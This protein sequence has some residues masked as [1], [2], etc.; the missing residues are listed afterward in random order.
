MKKHP[1]WEYL[2]QNNMTDLNESDFIMAYSDPEKAKKVWSYIKDN[3]M[4]SLD[5]RSFYNSYFSSDTEY[6]QGLKKKEPSSQDL[7]QRQERSGASSQPVSQ[8]VANDPYSLTEAS[9]LRIELKRQF[10]EFYENSKGSVRGFDSGIQNESFQKATANKDAIINLSNQLEALNPDQYREMAKGF[11]ESAANIYAEANNSKGST[12][13]TED[14]FERSVKNNVTW[15]DNN[16]TWLNNFINQNSGKNLSTDV[17]LN[18]TSKGEKRTDN[19]AQQYLQ[20]EAE[21]NAR[22]KEE[23]RQKPDAILISGG[24]I[25]NFQ[26]AE[27]QTNAAIA[28]GEDIRPKRNQY[29]TNDTYSKKVAEYEKRAKDRQSVYFKD[30]DV[31]EKER[32]ALTEQQ[33][34]DNTYKFI[35]E[36][37]I[38]SGFATPK[39]VVD[40]NGVTI[41][42]NIDIDWNKLPNDERFQQMF[43]DI[44]LEDKRMYENRAM[45]PKMYAQRGNN[46]YIEF[47]N[48]VK[49]SLLKG[50]Q[51]YYTQNSTSNKDSD[52]VIQ[53]VI[54]QNFNEDNYRP[55]LKKQDGTGTIILDIDKIN[56]S[57][58]K[59]A[60]H[61]NLPLDGT[62]RRNMYHKAESK[63]RSL[64]LKDDADAFLEANNPEL[65]EKLRVEKE[66]NPEAFQTTEEYLNLISSF[67]S[68][69][70]AMANMYNSLA[71]DEMDKLSNDF[72]AR[73][74]NVNNKYN[75][76]LS[77]IQTTLQ[78]LESA[79][80][81]NRISELEYGSQRIQL[82]K[83]YTDLYNQYTAEFPTQEEFL[84]AQNIALNAFTVKSQKE[85]DMMFDGLNQQLDQLFKK[86]STL[87]PALKAELEAAM[88]KAYGDAAD[89][90]G[91]EMERRFN[92]NESTNMAHSQ[93]RSYLSGSFGGFLKRIGEVT[94]SEGM[95]QYGQYLTE[96]FTRPNAKLDEFS[97]LLDFDNFVALLGEASGTTI[98][99]LAVTAGITIASRGIGAPAAFTFAVN[100][101]ASTAM[102]VAQASGSAQYDMYEKTGSVSKALNAASEATK[103]EMELWWLHI[104]DAL[105]FMK[106]FGGLIKTPRAV[107]LIL[108]P[109]IELAKETVEET[110][111]S[112]YELNISEGR[113]R[114]DNRVVWE[115]EPGQEGNVVSIKENL[116][117]SAPMSLI[118]GASDIFSK[119]DLTK[120]QQ[121]RIKYISDQTKKIVGNVVDDQQRQY[122]QGMVDKG[123]F[124]QAQQALAGMYMTGQIDIEEFSKVESYIAQSQKIKQTADEAK[125]KGVDRD[126]YSFFTARADE[127]RRMAEKNAND[128]VMSK[129]FEMQSK[130]YTQAAADFL[131]TR[132]VPTMYTV[133]HVDGTRTMMTDSDFRNAMNDDSFM[134]MVAADKIAVTA[135]GDGSKQ[136]MDMF[137]EKGKVYEQKV[138]EIREIPV[139]ED[140]RAQY[141]SS[142]AAKMAVSQ[143]ITRDEAVKIAT[144]EWLQTEDGIRY[145]NLNSK[146][147]TENKQ[148]ISSEEQQGKEPVQAE[149][150]Q[151]AGTTEVAPGG[152]VQGA[153]EEVV[154][155]EIPEVL[156]QE[157][158]TAEVTPE[159]IQES[160]KN[161]SIGGFT[162][163][164]TT[165]GLKTFSGDP[166]LVEDPRSTSNVSSPDF[167][168]RVVESEKDGK[169]VFTYIG[170]EVDSDSFGRPGF[171]SVSLQYPADT[172]LTADDVKPILQAKAA[173]AAGQIKSSPSAKKVDGSSFPALE[174]SP[175]VSA[176]AEPKA[177]TKTEVTPEIKLAPTTEV[178]PKKETK[179]SAAQ[180]EMQ[181]PEPLERND[182]NINEL[183]S[184]KNKYNSLPKT[185]KSIGAKLLDQIKQDARDMDMEVLTTRGLNIKIVDKKTKKPISK[186][187][188]SRVANKETAQK[189]R[190]AM[191][192]AQTGQLGIRA[193]ILRY[194]IGGGKAK[195]SQSELGA[196]SIEMKEAKKKG[197]IS[198]DSKT[199]SIDNI[200][201]YDIIS[202]IYGDA[203][204]AD[205]DVVD[206]VIAE[207]QD[208]LATYE[209][210]S[211]MEYDLMDM[212]DRVLADQEE[213]SRYSSM[214]EAN[215]AIDELELSED[216]LELYYESQNPLK[217]N[218]YEEY[219]RQAFPEYFNEEAEG[220]P[221]VGD[222]EGRKQEEK[223]KVDKRNK[224]RAELSG[225]F[226]EA[227]KNAETIRQGLADAGISVNVVS[228]EEMEDISKKKGQF[229]E[230]ADGIFFGDDGQIYLREDRASDPLFGK[231]LA[232]H[233]GIHPII[234]IIRNTNPKLYKAIVDGLNKLA[235]TNPGI[236]GAKDWANQYD[237][238]TKEDEFVVESLARLS[239]GEIDPLSIP[240]NLLDKIIDL[241]NKISKALFGKSPLTYRSS[242]KEVQKLSKQITD[243]FNGYGRLADVVGKENV[244][245]Y[246]YK[247]TAQPSTSRG[248]PSNVEIVNGF[249][250]PIEKSVSEFGKDKQKAK[251]WLNVVGKKDEAIYTGV[252]G[253]LEAKDPQEQVSKQDILDFMKDNRIEIKEKTISA[254]ETFSDESKWNKQKFGD[255]VWTMNSEDGTLLRIDAS[256]GDGTVRVFADDV[257]IGA[258]EY[259]GNAFEVGSSLLDQ[260]M[261]SEP[262]TKYSQY[263]LEG[264]KSGYKEVLVTL[265]SKVAPKENPNVVITKDFTARNGD[266]H[267][268]VLDKSTGEEY[269]HIGREGST[270]QSVRQE[271]LIKF[272]LQAAQRVGID[273]K[274][275]HFEEPNILVHLRMNTRTDA[276]GNK[277]LFL[278]EVQS[279]WGQ[280][281]KKRGFQAIGKF[282]KSKVSTKIKSP[283]RVD[284]YYDGKFI[285]DL[286]TG[287][288]TDEEVKKDVLN[289]AKDYFESTKMRSTPSAPFVTDTNAW[290]KL[291]LKFALQEAVKQGVNKIAWTTG[292]QQFDRW[293]SEK[294]DWIKTDD[295][296]NISIQEQFRGTAFEGM[297]VDEKALSKNGTAIKSKEDLKDSIDEVLSR[298][299][300][301]QERQKLADRVWDR[302]QNEDSGTS[303]PRKEGMESFYGSVE[304]NK[305]GIVGGVANALV[306]ELTGEPAKIKGANIN[307][308][309]QPSI[310]VTPDLIEQVNQGIPQFA[311][312]RAGGVSQDTILDAMDEIDNA[313]ESGV[314]AEQAIQENILNQPWYGQLSDDQ[315]AKVD[316]VINT[317]Y[318]VNP[319][320]IVTAS[321]SAQK[322]EDLY[323]SQEK[324]YKNKIQ[325]LLADD[326]ELKYIYNNIP[327]IL[328]ALEQEGVIKKNKNCP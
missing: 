167:T 54:D 282:D 208:V 209:D 287:Y 267:F 203:D 56:E 155:E 324:G 313:I 210:K 214:S 158:V 260:D 17:K 228:K 2:K 14:A 178:A 189:R 84:R 300:T 290:T 138:G 69:T 222:V 169:K 68:N 150:V 41:V 95:V 76:Q 116:I 50:L 119:G 201:R 105:P 232:F 315:K 142:R 311:V 99:T 137:K 153:Q 98:P 80:A 310:D 90:R 326:P 193:A 120:E 143:G 249:Y 40:D 63:M 254:F 269:K 250:S 318:G 46:A 26:E 229:K 314:S 64:M 16:S 35:N 139:L 129:V 255:G 61:Y 77:Q 43:P 23:M 285:D 20:E 270:P 152:V 72:K 9:K 261:G 174:T 5:E 252:R 288:S 238:Q 134:T 37:A 123:Q 127:S 317:E 32:D 328:N 283:N 205:P 97:D 202:S 78:E 284:V 65:M 194:F 308:Q 88:N 204:N 94:G 162:I 118:G 184:K 258:D 161:E 131:T 44:S 107:N 230:V 112:N 286:F 19:K 115:A 110:L 47:E 128:P 48:K 253:W 45:N 114:W 280:E 295:G 271:V 132:I 70:L 279:D 154:Q 28:A 221:S 60:D 51:D 233:E 234:N 30:W 289:K 38:S 117:F 216:E 66:K 293:G 305:E 316:S 52:V 246:E 92:A 266:V 141:V 29:D 231:G 10:E 277:V 273:F 111:Q 1:I 195:S 151:G 130:D 31:Y 186:R 49:N 27:A 8:P 146:Y 103:A 307:N 113:N 188:V 21:A 212:Y 248:L 292:E 325:D 294:I 85:Y 102:G 274:S 237:D 59:I 33:N 180:L 225:L 278:E 227:E 297:N 106:G 145:T 264:D 104:A 42:E 172:K 83:A 251:D 121:D 67:K 191:S 157:E 18:L 101:I 309:V 122:F 217:Q 57:I 164:A 321:E 275:T 136:S 53:K 171:I 15:F 223:P 257:E 218:E 13:T 301:E 185:K 79:R 304:Q 265:P 296:W 281:G 220:A 124:S 39:T 299:K 73:M 196:G 240:K 259:D 163:Q 159:Q 177:E 91:N 24:P 327:K 81:A 245:K 34:N 148:G 206:E 175:K 323:N 190:E 236:A 55:Y 135:Y 272:D 319:S 140:K 215:A 74:D 58:D 262:K 96:E 176:Q 25:A 11:R 62:V 192:M 241:L 263:Q 298:E 302:M 36:N 199:A 183:L 322:L 256:E 235:Q 198:D 268:N 303:L 87:D 173:E 170:D 160:V 168:G 242:P 93:Y 126:V 7:S 165:N 4:T 75:P 179:P 276:D 166:N 125:L 109:G 6:Y 312:G 182:N 108:K 156:P 226:E 306:K 144:D 147:D 197:L 149:P 86:Y 213:A 181:I 3:G 243:L 291:G 219:Y 187:G 207:I 22:F 211:D 247:K 12:F 244:S 239:S 224:R 133:E 82:E 89:L 200:A 320:E 71:K 100:T